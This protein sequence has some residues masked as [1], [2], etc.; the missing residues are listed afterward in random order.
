MGTSTDYTAPP[1]WSQLK[2]KVTRSGNAPL[3]PEKSRD[4]LNDYVSNNGGSGK[5]SSGG[6]QLGTGRTART[7]G[8]SLGGFFSSVAANG[9][10]NTLR[11]SGLQNLIGKSLTD[12]ILGIVALCGGTDGDQDSVDARQAISRTMDELCADS[13]TPEEL[14]VKLEASVSADGLGKLLMQYFGNYLY[15][16]FCRVFFSQ[17][18][19]RHGDTK[20]ESF[21][22]DI[23]DVIKSNVEH[24]TFGED[25]T[26]VDW[27]GD[28]GNKMAESIMK[29]TFEIF[30]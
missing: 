25:L 10:E 22:G 4:I 15:E 18:V 23:K 6:G 19:K 30:E 29:N 12:L 17:L 5:I 8:S 3:T 27:F 26:K 20:A 2:S 7:A 13:E 16:Q 21:L 14:E 9:L 11:D 28:E 1:N 24:T